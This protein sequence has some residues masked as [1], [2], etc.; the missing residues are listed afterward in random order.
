[1]LKSGL[2]ASTAAAFLHENM[3]EF[4]HP[5]A[6]EDAAEACLFLSHAGESDAEYHAS[7]MLY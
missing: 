4:V 1:M 3:L 6:V 2:E 5:D 7:A